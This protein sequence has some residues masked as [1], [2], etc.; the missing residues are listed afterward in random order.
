MAKIKVEQ[1][2]QL[3]EKTGAGVMEAKQ[4]LTASGGKMAAAEA[5]I[6]KKG[7]DRAEAKTDR[8]TK[9][10]VVFAYIHHDHKSGAMV[11]LLCE[12]DFV[13]RTDDFLNLAQELAMQA[14]SMPAKNTA[15]LL[16]QAYIR[17][18]EMTVEQLIKQVAGKVGENIQLKEFVR[19]GL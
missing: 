9:Q 5:W 6:K 3:R 11:K 16:S 8:E 18:L 14:T 1:I 7:L 10:G 4:A 15:A 13:A 12:T 19:L 17:D 2:K